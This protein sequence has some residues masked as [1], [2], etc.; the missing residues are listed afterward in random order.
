MQ[1]NREKYMGIS[2]SLFLIKS[3]L[4][5]KNIHVKFNLPKKCVILFV[6]SCCKCKTKK[7]TVV[8]ILVSKYKD[9]TYYRCQ[10]CESKNKKA[11]YARHK[12]RILARNRLNNKRWYRQNKQNKLLKNKEWRQA[13][14]ERVRCYHREYQREKRK[15]PIYRLHQAISSGVRKVLKGEK[16]RSKWEALLGF[17][18]EDLKSHLQSKFKKGMSW[19]NYGSWTID[20]IKPISHFSKTEFKECWS[21]ANLQP[22]WASENFA[23]GNR[24]VG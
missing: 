6:K 15:D 3:S 16:C 2:F 21:L 20:H 13:N 11:V 10:E 9:A 7:E 8:Y 23:K 14:G 17:A 24:Y 5:I 18:V 19:D 1:I 4:N 12:A 22:L